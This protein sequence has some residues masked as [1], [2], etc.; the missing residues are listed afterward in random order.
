MK[1]E[2][3]PFLIAAVAQLLLTAPSVQAETVESQG[4]YRLVEQCR[5][6]AQNGHDSVSAY[7]DV[8]RHKKAMASI[9]N[10]WIEIAQRPLEERKALAPDMQRLCTREAMSGR[11]GGAKALS[12]LTTHKKKGVDICSQLSQAVSQ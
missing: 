3:I 1:M 6:I 9:C 4:L 10:E 12:S 8:A 7:S 2:S 5:E 11:D